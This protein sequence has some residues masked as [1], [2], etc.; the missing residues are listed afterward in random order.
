MKAN[1]ASSRR[2]KEKEQTQPFCSD[3]RKILHSKAYSRYADKTQ[4]VYLFPH[5]H[6]SSR[7]L[8]VQLVSFLARSIGGKLFFDEDLI[9]AISLG[10]DMGHAPFGHEGELYLSELSQEH[11]GGAFSHSRQSCR[12]AEDIEQL[13]LTFAVLDGFLTHDGGLQS[14]CLS[15]NPKKTWA[16]YD[17]EL[18]N[19]KFEP[20]IDLEPFSLEGALVKICDTV[21]YLQRDL[22][23]ALTLGIIQE[24]QLKKAGISLDCY[25]IMSLV[26]KDI[27]SSF[28]KKK[29]ICL[30]ASTYRLLKK[31]RKFNFQN[32]YVHAKLKTES[33]KIHTAYRL[34]FTEL[35]QGFK[36]RGKGSLLW[37]HYLHSKD[38]IYVE[39]N[40]EVQLVVD[41]IAG[42]TDGYFLR[43]FETLFVPKTIAVPDVLPFS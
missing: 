17:Q 38:P 20:E 2:V 15:I 41:Y 33:R 39:K 42:M 6:I 34:L 25:A 40:S 9:E 23:D 26:E 16:I 19:R 43:L 36:K 12:I 7:G 13:N 35:L 21:C 32:I 29:T 18:E 14:S 22:Q 30:S 24:L 11:G 10:H 1:I 8:H 5:D 4:V 27:V 37:R 28:Q 31:M 3:V